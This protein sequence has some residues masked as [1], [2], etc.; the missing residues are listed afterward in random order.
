MLCLLGDRPN[1]NIQIVL[2]TTKWIKKTAVPFGT[3]AIFKCARYF[4]S[5]NRRQN[6]GQL[7]C[8]ND[9]IWTNENILQNFHC[10]AG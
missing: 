7:T 4:K 8:T 5:V 10:E 6:S 2:Q 3:T 1:K 9:G